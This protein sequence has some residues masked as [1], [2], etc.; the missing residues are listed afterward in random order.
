MTGHWLDGA[1]CLYSEVSGLDLSCTVS[2][3]RAGTCSS[4]V[5]FVLLDY[6]TRNCI[7]TVAILAQVLSPVDVA[8]TDRHPAKDVVCIALLGWCEHPEG[9]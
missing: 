4:I 9:L 2:A 8:L 6:S 1:S 5:H 3:P 7:I